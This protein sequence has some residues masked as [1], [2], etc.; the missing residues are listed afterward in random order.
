ME[1]EVKYHGRLEEAAIEDLKRKHGEVYELIVP[2]DDEGNEFAVGY[3]KK[4]ARQ[5]LG[6]TSRLLDVNPI[7]ANEM[8]LKEIWLSGDERIKTDDNLFLSASIEIPNLVTVRRAM[9]KKK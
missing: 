3:V 4:P 6:K 2:M 8:I 5:L 1:K 7:A 9:L